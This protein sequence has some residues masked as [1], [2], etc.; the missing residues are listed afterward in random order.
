MTT[1]VTAPGAVTPTAPFVVSAPETAVVLDQRTRRGGASLTVYNNSGQ[2]LRARARLVSVDPAATAWFRLD[3]GPQ[4]SPADAEWDLPAGGQRP[5]RVQCD[6]P[7][8]AE[9]GTYKVHVDV[10]STAAP[11]ATLVSGPTLSVTVP[12]TAPAAGKPWYTARPVLL[13]VAAL[14]LALLGGALFWA[15]TRAQERAAY[16]EA[17]AT[18]TATAQETATAAVATATAAARD[19]ATAAATATA[20]EQFARYDGTW[21]SGD[22]PSKGISRL[23]IKSNGPAITVSALTDLVDVIVRDH[24]TATPSSQQLTWRQDRCRTAGGCDLGKPRQTTYGSDSLLV[25]FETAPSPRIVHRLTITL[26]PGGTGL[27]VVEGIEVD[28]KP[29][30]VN[31]YAFVKAT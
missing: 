24:R 27:S 6:A 25:V 4:S 31:D 1:V 15:Q 13:A 26:P 23:V 29:Q 12:A 11:E 2:A 7:A 17:V 28:G 16:E 3:D 18:A 9:P 20:Q 14:T 19:E 8:G 22:G 30:R 21:I 5:L 10:W